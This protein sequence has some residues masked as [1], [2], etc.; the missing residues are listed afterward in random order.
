MGDRG[1]K[2]QESSEKEKL[3]LNLPTGEFLQ[4]SVPAASKGTGGN[5]ECVRDAYMIPVL[6]DDAL[7]AHLQDLAQHLVQHSKDT[8]W[9]DESVNE[10]A[11]CGLEKLAWSILRQHESRYGLQGSMGAEWWVQVKPVTDRR[12]ESAIDLH[13]DKDEALAES[14]GIGRFPAL[15]T[16][17]YLNDAA[18]PTVV[19]S[20]RYDEADSSI[21]D[22]L[23]SYPLRGKQLVFDGRL[24][25][26]APAHPALRKPGLDD[27]ISNGEKESWRI[28]F[29]VNIWVGHKPAGVHPLTIEIRESLSKIDSGDCHRLDV[30]SLECIPAEVSE[31]V[32]SKIE[33]LGGTDVLRIHLPFLGKDTTWGE[34]GDDSERLVVSMYVPPPSPSLGADRD[35]SSVVG[36]TLLLR[37]EPSVGAY[38]C[39]PSDTDS[40]EGE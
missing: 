13:Y 19:F 8:F 21:A 30:V 28:T 9:I 27:R 25:H 37:F 26:G 31:R 15:S 5:R 10:A 14:F 38:L 32:F 18:S 12:H 11:T 36:D 17:T 20:H 22:V 2:I 29:L 3:R 24:L 39:N 7:C 35:R 6:R 23:V 1:C 33:E 40:E 4:A 34:D 16:V